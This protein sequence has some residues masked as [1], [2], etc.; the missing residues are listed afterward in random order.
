MLF[1]AKMVAS[2]SNNLRLIWQDNTLYVSN[3][4]Y[5]APKGPGR[6][7]MRTISE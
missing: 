7:K 3:A 5:I 4:Y 2:A 1:I 6:V